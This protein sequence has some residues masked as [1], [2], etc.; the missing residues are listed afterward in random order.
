M[1]VTQEEPGIQTF[2]PRWPAT[3]E[4]RGLLTFVYDRPTDTLFVDFYGR[5]LPAASIALEWGDHDYAFAR[6]DPETHGVVGLQIEEF[7]LHAESHNPWLLDALEYA[8]LRGITPREVEE[9]RRRLAPTT[10]EARGDAGL[11][12][13]H[14]ARMTA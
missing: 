5:S 1:A 7:L 11:F 4:V 13:D 14:L 10:S 8:E 9:L 12:L 2:S 3:D 6:V